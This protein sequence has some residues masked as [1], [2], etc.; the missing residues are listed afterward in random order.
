MFLINSTQQII[1]ESIN[2][3]LLIDCLRCMNLQSRFNEEKIYS[4]PKSIDIFKINKCYFMDYENY[5][6]I[7]N[8]EYNFVVNNIYDNLNN[9][10]YNINKRIKLK[11]FW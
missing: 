10:S 6:M 7:F 8:D 5:T 11:N 4:I 2:N 9:L 3:N 1:T